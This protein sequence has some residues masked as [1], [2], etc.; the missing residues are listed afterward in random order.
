MFVRIAP[1]VAVDAPPASYLLNLGA[2]GEARHRRR[3]GAR[4]LGA[5]APVVGT[6]RVASALGEIERA[7]DLAEL[8]A[9]AEPD[10]EAEA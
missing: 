1:L 5:V 8:D 4:R 3:P 6:A 9:E 7:L 2:A 10:E